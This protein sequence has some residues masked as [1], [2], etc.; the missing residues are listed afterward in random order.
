[1]PEGG[2]RTYMTFALDDKVIRC[3]GNQRCRDR[4]RQ[5]QPPG[6]RGLRPRTE[7][8]SA[9]WA[10]NTDLAFNTGTGRNNDLASYHNEDPRVTT[11][12]WKALH[13]G[14]S[15]TSQ[16]AQ[17]WLWSARGSSS[18]PGCAHFGRA[19]RPGRPGLGARHK[20]RPGH[21]R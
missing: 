1:M 10:Y 15:Y 13:G 17:T 8:D 16:L 20:R 19:V 3:D 14:E 5:A 18:T 6:N 9:V 21:H 4:S 2:R 7:S 12:H 11:E